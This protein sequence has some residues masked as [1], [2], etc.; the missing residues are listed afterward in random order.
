MLVK[1]LKILILKS[2]WNNTL[3]GK[4]GKT[5]ESWRTERERDTSLHKEV[6]NILQRE[7]KQNCKDESADRF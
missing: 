2:K 6:G 4:Q 1:H 3:I 7:L 5:G